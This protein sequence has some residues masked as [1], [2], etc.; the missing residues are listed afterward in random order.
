MIQNP[1]IIKGYAGKAYFCDREE[2]TQKLVT[3][4]LGASDSA[5]ISP[6]RLGKSGLV[7]HVLETIEAEHPEIKTLYTDIYATSSLDDLVENLSSAILATFPA[8][9]RFGKR[10]MDFMK[11]I[12]PYLTFDPLSGI[13]QFHLDFATPV[14]KEAT[15]KSIFDLLDDAGT[16]L[17]FAIDEFQQITE[18]PEKNVEA[19]LRTY[20]QNLHNIRF[21]FSGSKRRLMTAMFN[22]ATRPFYASVESL[23]LGKLNRKVYS[24]FIL[25]MF[26][27]GDRTMEMDA[28]DFVL[29]WTRIHTYYTQRVCHNLFDTG[30][31]HLTLDI[32]RKVCQDILDGES[33]NYLQLREI[34]PIQQWRFLI[35]LAKEEKVTQI[36]AN[37][38]ISKYKIGSAATSRRAAESLE[39]KELIL[40]TP[41]LGGTVYEVY[42]VFFSRWLQ[43]TY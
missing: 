8:K 12:R 27:K 42:D 4:A 7:M 34:L 24:E 15:L 3:R 1:F 36:T 38:F 9:T 6:R 30:E 26:R 22:D 32:A 28:L 25:S 17:V 40:K 20:T 21:L 19:L 14:Q 37:S 16:P 33:F 43:L 23:S 31:K 5:I 2:E 39:E 18:Y 41:S 35:G 29:D 10:F 13:P 11:S